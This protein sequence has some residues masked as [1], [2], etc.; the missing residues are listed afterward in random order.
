MDI[1]SE[2]LF[3]FLLPLLTEQSLPVMIQESPALKP[4]CDDAR[5]DRVREG[6]IGQS[7]AFPWL[8]LLKVYLRDSNISQTAVTGLVLVTDRHAIVNARDVAHMPEHVFKNASTVMFIPKKGQPWHTKPKRYTIHP[9]YGVSTYN[10]IALVEL[11]YDRRA[12][13]NNVM[14]KMIHSLHIL[15]PSVCKYYYQKV[16]SKEPK[17][18][19]THLKCAMAVSNAADCAWEAGAALV[20]NSSGKWTLLTRCIIWMLLE[21]QIGFGIYSESCS[22]PARFI[23]IAAYQPW[24]AS[25]AAPAR[26]ALRATDGKNFIGKIFEERYPFDAPEGEGQYTPGPFQVYKIDN[27]YQLSIVPELPNYWERSKGGCSDFKTLIYRDKVKF[28]V[29]FDQ[30][31]IAQFRI[32]LYDVMMANYTCI[33]FQIQNRNLTKNETQMWFNTYD[34]EEGYS[35][36]EGQKTPVELLKYHSLPQK[37][38][39]ANEQGNFPYKWKGKWRHLEPK[40]LEY[41]QQPGGDRA[42]IERV[43]ILIGFY[44]EGEATLDVYVYGVPHIRKLKKYTTVKTTTTRSQHSSSTTEDPDLYWRSRDRQEE[45]FPGSEW[46]RRIPFKFPKK[47]KDKFDKAKERDAERK[48]IE[49]RSEGKDKR[50]KGNKELKK[51]RAEVKK[52]MMESGN[53]FDFTPIPPSEEFGTFSPEGFARYMHLI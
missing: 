47:K 43:N 51:Q 1:H 28:V 8:G 48:A 11:E 39:L 3:V 9:E 23:D 38:D 46:F 24:V 10:T 15:K 41:K 16:T 27:A 30:K 18:P 13:E 14:E 17:S 50:K 33:Q 22:A 4:E 35:A 21:K 40:F 53:I 7:E 44:F 42:R 32:S 12:Q 19:P 25:V 52:P 31:N 36:V 29:G 34:S 45:T 6:N 20:S 26:P 5:Y 49:M 37:I 2:V